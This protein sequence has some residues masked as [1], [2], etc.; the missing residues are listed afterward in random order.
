MCSWVNATRTGQALSV[1]QSEKSFFAKYS[2]ELHWIYHPTCEHLF[3]NRFTESVLWFAGEQSSESRHKL[4]LAKPPCANELHPGNVFSAW[5]N[6]T[7]AIL[8]CSLSEPLCAGWECQGPC[9]TGHTWAEVSGSTSQVS[10]PEQ[11]GNTTIPS[12]FLTFLG[13]EHMLLPPQ[14]ELVC[15]QV[16]LQ[17]GALLAPQVRC[18]VSVP[19]AVWR[20]SDDE[21]CPWLLPHPWGFSCH[22]P[23]DNRKCGWCFA[24]S[25]CSFCRLA[26]NA[27]KTK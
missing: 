12:P 19:A 26:H 6:C 14:E 16:K 17:R 10:S 24:P 25:S 27:L 1:A 23:V 20:C 22:V 2:L 13:H 4:A 21:Q 3:A 9:G 8:P 18:W 7:P 15:L 11:G 5:G